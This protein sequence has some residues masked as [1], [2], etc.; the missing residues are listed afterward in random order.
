MHRRTVGLTVLCAAAAGL[1]AAVTIPADASTE[2]KTRAAGPGGHT[3]AASAAMFAALQRD[4]G[5]NP[6]QAR[7]RLSREDDA[8][9]ADAQLRAKLG[10]KFAGSW[11][12][13]D[14]GDLVVAV[15]D[16]HSAAQVRAAGVKA[17]I[18]K[19]DAAHL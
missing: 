18:V 15:T 10:P 7:A 13:K 17:R 5:L 9:H 8:A 14:A 12:E 11:L 4:L 2:D 3:S 16:A 6:E 1:V 19:R